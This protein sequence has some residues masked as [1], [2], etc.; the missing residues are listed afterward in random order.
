MLVELEIGLKQKD[1]LENSCL[2]FVQEDSINVDTA[3]VILLSSHLSEKLI[4]RGWLTR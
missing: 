4:E 1:L 2:S 3:R